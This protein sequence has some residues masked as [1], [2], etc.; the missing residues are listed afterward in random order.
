MKPDT[1][2]PLM[3]VNALIAQGREDHAIKRLEQAIQQTPSRK[4]L[5]TRLDQLYMVRGETQFNPDRTGLYP[6]I[7]LHAA[8]TVL[9]YLFFSLGPIIFS[10]LLFRHDID[11]IKVTDWIGALTV[12]VAIVFALAA[13]FTLGT[14]VFCI[15]WSIYI[16]RF[17]D[18]KRRLTLLMQLE[19]R[20][21]IRHPPLAETYELGFKVRKK[22]GRRK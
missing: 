16:D 3:E 9:M 6:N 15:V 5:R 14:F 8:A 4:D 19:P 1:D 7:T 21:L 12:F 13:L 2:D 17:T 11:A 18:P 10:A 20:M 22:L